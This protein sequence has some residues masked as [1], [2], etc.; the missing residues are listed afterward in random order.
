MILR[1]RHRVS[2]PSH[3]HILSVLVQPIQHLEF[4]LRSNSWP[5]TP[6]RLYGVQLRLR[7][8]HFLF[9]CMGQAGPVPPWPPEF[10]TSHL[11]IVISFV[12]GL[13][14]IFMGRRMHWRHNQNMDLLG[15]G[16]FEWGAAGSRC[17]TGQSL[18]V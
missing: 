7:L 10:F 18:F 6:F 2:L 1:S 8:I 16:V 11:V 9:H 14:R 5:D 12:Y 3:P 15:S 4:I 17:W 13:H